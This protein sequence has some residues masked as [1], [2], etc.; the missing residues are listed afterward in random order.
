MIKM[1][2]ERILTIL[3]VFSWIAFIGI[4]IKC[5]ALIFTYSLSLF[6]EQVAKDLYEG[7]NL[8]DLKK[9]SFL[10]YTLTLFLQVAT[11]AIKAYVAQQV[12]QVLSKINLKSPF[13]MEVAQR[14]EKISFLILSIWIISLVSMLYQESWGLAKADW[15]GGETLFLSG[16]VFVFAQIF[17]KGAE[18]QSENE[19]TV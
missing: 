4:S 6:N 13:D 10:A 19:L 15:N 8:Y 1:K 2:T 3:N 18:I 7:L 11:L 17:K 5:G 14:I 9:E 16:L 12:I